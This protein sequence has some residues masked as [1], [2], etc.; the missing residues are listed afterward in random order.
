MNNAAQSEL[1]KAI[2]DLCT[3]AIFFCMRSCKY[4]KVP[5]QEDKKTKLLCL[6]NLRFFKNNKLLDQQLDEIENA[7]LISITFEDQKN[8]E[9]NQAINLHR[10]KDSL[11]CPIKAWSKVVKR[12]RSYNGSSKD[13]PVNSFQLNNKPYRITNNNITQALRAS[14]DRMSNT[15]NL[16][17]TSKD[18]GTHSICLGG[19]MAM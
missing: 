13:S 11:L 3:G 18:V 17:F 14:V 6:R 12:V 4:S 19:A 15:H 16:G 9:K 1:D 10:S 8:R 7:T 5:C 2:A